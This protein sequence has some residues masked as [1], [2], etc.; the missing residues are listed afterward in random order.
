[1]KE[2]F[3]GVEEVKD[4]TNTLR[5]EFDDR[6]EEMEDRWNKKLEAMEQRLL[7]ALT[8]DI[9]K[10]RVFNAE[11]ISSLTETVKAELRQ[12]TNDIRDTV[13]QEL[14][15]G[16]FIIKKVDMSRDNDPRETSF[17]YSEA[18]GPS[19]ERQQI[20]VPQK[21][22]PKRS[23]KVCWKDFPQ[24]ED[25]IISEHKKFQWKKNGAVKKIIFGAGLKRKLWE[26]DEVWRKR[27]CYKIDS[28]YKSNILLCDRRST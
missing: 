5:R 1:M 26:D 7:Q 4:V 8:D 28:L 15:N 12:S 22:Q 25:F 17:I 9:K 19:T 10:E 14:E 3:M 20:N 24:Q 18:A 27:V 23:P 13:N 2:N 11:N 16:V 6:L 21:T